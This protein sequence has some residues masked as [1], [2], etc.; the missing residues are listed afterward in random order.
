MSEEE[1]MQSPLTVIREQTNWGVV[2]VA[3]QGCCHGELDTIYAK[4]CEAESS[5]G[6]K[7]DLLLICGDFEC[8]RDTVDLCCM[9][10]PP[11]YRHLKNF[12]KYF[13]GECTA[14]VKTVFIGGNHEASNVLQS[15]YYGGYVA[16]NIFFLGW[17]AVVNFKGLRI[18]GLSGIYNDKHYTHGHF[19]RPPYSDNT[20]RSIYHVRAFEVQQMLHFP[21]PSSP[22]QISNRN[23][24]IFLTHDWPVRVWEHGDIDTLLQIKPYFRS[25]I[26]KGVLGSA[27]AR[28]LMDHLQPPFWFAGH[29]HYKFAAVVPHAAQSSHETAEGTSV[30]NLVTT[31][32]RCTRF[33]ALDKVIPGR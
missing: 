21:T 31:E 7:V 29:M 5:T 24:D 33:L 9:A 1:L 15:L 13:N 2:N 4:V 19:E 11:K 14:P 8:V 27:P 12:Y 30:N 28:Q 26:E 22:I 17:A 3:V 18:G 25:D 23:I 6:T 10:V 20:M 16:P 32:S